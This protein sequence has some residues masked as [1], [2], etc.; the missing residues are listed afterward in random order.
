MQ[1]ARKKKKKE[2]RVLSLVR[3]LDPTC[4]SRAHMPHLKVRHATA[5]AWCSQNKKVGLGCWEN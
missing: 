4:H 5:E 1:E 3:E 2:A